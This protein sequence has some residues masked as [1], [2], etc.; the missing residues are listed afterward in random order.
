MSSPRWPARPGYQHVVITGRDADPRPD[1]GRRPRHRDDQGQAPDGRRAK[2]PAGHRVV[3]LP[4]RVVIAAPASGDGKTTVATGL[5]AA[6]GAR[7]LRVSPHKVGPDYIDPELPRRWRPA[8]RPQPRPRAGRR[9]ADRPAASLHGARRTPTSRSSRASWA[10]STARPGRGDYASTAHVARLLD[11]PSCWSSTRLR[12]R[13][14]VAA[15]VHG[16]ASYDPRVRIAGCR[17]QPGVLAPARGSP[18]G[19]ARRTGIPVLGALRREAALHTPSRHLGLVP[20]AERTPGR[21]RLAA[22][23]RELSPAT[24]TW[25]G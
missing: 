17:A 2:G 21:R 11:A 13:R 18:A 3:S 16:F 10:C 19:G 15:T 14:S 5:M 24:W 7:G 8:A 6:L 20:A 4:P 1:R 25:T 9:G 12:S 22:A 23:L